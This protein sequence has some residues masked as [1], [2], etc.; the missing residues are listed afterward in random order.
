[1]KKLK[2]LFI[3]FAV[4]VLTACSKSL[5]Q[6][7]AEQLELGQKYLMEQNYEEAIVAFNKVIELE[8]KCIEAYYELAQAQMGL[9][10][11]EDM[12]ETLYKG[13]GLVQDMEDSEKTE[14]AVASYEKMIQL[15]ES[16]LPDYIT[17]LINENNSSDAKKYNQWL[18]EITGA[19][20]SWFD[21]TYL[22][23]IEEE[24]YEE[25]SGFYGE[26]KDCISK[27]QYPYGY[28]DEMNEE[29]II[30]NHEYKEKLAGLYD[31]AKRE[32]IDSVKELL[33]GNTE[34]F[35]LDNGEDHVY[36]SSYIKTDFYYGEKIYYGE[37]DKFGYP[38][39]FGAALCDDHGESGFIVYIGT[40]KDGKREGEGSYMSVNRAGELDCYD[41]MW[42]DDMPNGKG[43]IYQETNRFDSNTGIY[44]DLV[45]WEKETGQ[46][47]NG[48]YDGAF[49]KEFSGPKDFSLTGHI[50]QRKEEFQK[51]RAVP[52]KEGTI[53]PVFHFEGRGEICLEPLTI[54]EDNGNYTFC[55]G[56]EIC[57]GLGTE[58]MNSS[59]NGV[60]FDHY[61]P[62]TAQ[63]GYKWSVFH[64]F[65]E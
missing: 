54:Y 61:M 49:I 25:A 5:E 28:M 43:T 37:T 34:Y 63:A 39:G 16:Y 31:V 27:K 48:L 47:V 12:F 21:E 24:Q 65:Q 56:C 20:N 11:S 64:G 46:F 45:H 19:D 13:I 1:M 3:I 2:G 57:I 22:R 41:G 51:G 26:Y 33:K 7:I 6:Q 50:A 60:A 29:H 38:S 58:V 10:H 15:A 62:A 17:K 35:H 52:L 14:E 55:R 23:Y 30:I 9:G 18:E 40:W 36:I 53:G 59:T 42:K 8:P 32:G 44:I 4:I